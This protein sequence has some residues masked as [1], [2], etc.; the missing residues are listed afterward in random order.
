ML[1]MD[2][3]NFKSKIVIN[4]QL[5]SKKS[6]YLGLNLTGSVFDRGRGFDPMGRYSLIDNAYRFC[7]DWLFSSSLFV[8][9]VGSVSNS[10]CSGKFT[11]ELIN[12]H[13]FESDPLFYDSAQWVLAKTGKIL[14]LGTARSLNIVVYFYLY[15]DDTCSLFDRGKCVVIFSF[16]YWKLHIQL[17]PSFRYKTNFWDIH[18]VHVCGHANE[19]RGAL[20]LLDCWV[21]DRGKVVYVFKRGSYFVDAYKVGVD[22]NTSGVT[23]L[24]WLISLNLF[25]ENLLYEMVFRHGFL[26]DSL[27]LNSRCIVLLK[28]DDGDRFQLFIDT[29]ESNYQILLFLLDRVV[30]TGKTLELLGRPL[31]NIVWNWNGGEADII[32]QPQNGWPN[33]TGV[34]LGAL[35]TVSICEHGQGN[36]LLIFW[37][38]FEC[39]PMLLSAPIIVQSVTS[40]VYETPSFRETVLTAVAYSTWSCLYSFYSAQYFWSCHNQVVGVYEFHST[41]YLLPYYSCLGDLVSQSNEHYTWP[42]IFATIIRLQH[43]LDEVQ[44]SEVL[45]LE[46]LLMGSSISVNTVSTHLLQV[47]NSDLFLLSATFSP[48]IYETLAVLE[49]VELVY[50]TK[51]ELFA[52]LSRIQVL[53]TVM[54]ILNVLIWFE[55]LK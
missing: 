13:G 50:S 25:H 10:Y 23:I 26:L 52:I 16:S 17:I 28:N 6:S 27:F 12:K 31:G 9:K 32:L 33:A 41:R 19:I 55:Y 38:E 5:F 54:R 1:Q 34:I 4:H 15:F 48:A 37:K 43:M 14:L 46:V 30:E 29:S 53:L 45:I 44:V 49:A 2:V 22:T 24:N 11:Q 35:R 21:Y 39:L 36:V 8:L 51:L 7:Y 40:E 47:F 42:D 18:S 20:K 3:V